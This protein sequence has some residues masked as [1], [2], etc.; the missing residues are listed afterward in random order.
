MR[1]LQVGQFPVPLLCCSS[2]W[3]AHPSSPSSCARPRRCKA[4][5]LWC[6]FSW[7]GPSA[8]ALSRRSRRRSWPPPSW[9]RAPYAGVELSFPRWAGDFRA[10]L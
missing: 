7:T 5:P 4:A 3:T 10:H 8:A 2:A 9:A 6:C 1:A